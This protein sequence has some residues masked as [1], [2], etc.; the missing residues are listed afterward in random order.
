MMP[1]PLSALHIVHLFSNPSVPGL[2]FL[3]LSR[4]QYLGRSLQ[5]DRKPK[6]KL[7]ISPHR[8]GMVECVRQSCPLIRFGFSQ[9]LF[10]FLPN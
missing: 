1:V 7:V 8:R 6:S 3:A 5:L 9:E 2:P 10:T 4:F